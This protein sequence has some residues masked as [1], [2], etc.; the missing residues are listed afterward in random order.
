MQNRISRW[1]LL[2][3]L[4]LPSLQALQALPAHALEPAA[5]AA[6]AQDRLGVAGPQ[7]VA[8]QV[9]RLAFVTPPSANGHVL[10]EYLPAGQQLESYTEMLL[11]SHVPVQA[12]PLQLAQHKYQE[13]QARRSG[14]DALANGELLEGPDGSA[15]LDF[16]MSATL[17]DGRLVVEWN[18]YHYRQQAAGITLT[19][20]SRRAY[21]DEAA[22]TFLRGLKQRRLV[23]RE[24]VLAWLPT[25][26]RQG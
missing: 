17:P 7:Q 9:Y 8:G 15:V 12:T 13:I 16:V 18:A 19:A 5:S 11:L 26:Q 24:A 1:P 10:Q 23:D 21:G 25:V 4:L 22:T 3:A 2:L 14:G 6:S 20:L